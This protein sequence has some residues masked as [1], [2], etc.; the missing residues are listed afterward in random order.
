MTLTREQQEHYARLAALEEQPG[1]SSGP[2]ESAFG[3]EAA[4]IGRQMLLEALGSEEAVRKAVGGRPRVGGA[5]AG[6]GESPT[7]RVRVTPLR[8][9]Q[10]AMLKKQIHVKHEAD[11]VRAALD[12]YVAN[13]LQEV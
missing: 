4:A 12:E 13:H 8:K 3:G 10:I 7:I 9:Q 6:D 1:G 2:G 11:V 5:P